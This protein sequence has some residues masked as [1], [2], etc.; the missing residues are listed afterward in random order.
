V[1]IKNV[2]YFIKLTR[3]LFLAGGVLLYLLGAFM[4]VSAGA[5][6]SLSNLL[7]GQALITTIQ[8]MTHYSNEYYDLEGDRLNAARTWFSGGSGVLSS[9]L[10]DPR[11]ALYA[12]LGL[13]GVA[14][15]LLAAAALRVPVV[16]AF[17]LAG[18]LAAWSYSGPPFYL[19][20]SGWGE[21]SASLVVA[22]FVPLVGYTMQS[23][24]QVSGALLVT[25]LPLV[26]IHFAMLIAF[27]IPDMPADQASGKRTLAVRLGLERVVWVHNLSIALGFVIL[28]GLALMRWP[29]TQLAWLTLPLAAWQLGA[30]R[31]CARPVNASVPVTGSTAGSD[32]RPSYGW[33][34][35]RA[36][37]LFAVTAA[38][39]LAGIAAAA[40]R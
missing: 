4:A 28:L 11:L 23:G 18:L 3:P 39:W 40:L 2:W 13:V 9:G 31:R 24:G 30:I 29:G 26:L 36:L 5:S 15:G 8:L 34:T 27:Q 14:L 37:S 10:L 22:F 20:R 16:L 6:F 32:A 33:L 35:F 38:L 12:A 25:C 19:S 1:G 17:G 7:L 21:L